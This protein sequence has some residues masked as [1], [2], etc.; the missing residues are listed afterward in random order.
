MTKFVTSI[1]VIVSMVFAVMAAPATAATPRKYEN[2][3]ALKKDY[4]GGVALANGWKNKG[5]KLKN[6]PVVNARVYKLNSSKDRD[7]DKI[8]CES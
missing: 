7:G 4:P 5:S 3:T 1:G 6:T 8:A 2:C